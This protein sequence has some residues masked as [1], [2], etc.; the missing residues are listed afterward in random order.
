M[1]L[2][3]C[4]INKAIWTYWIRGCKMIR[5]VVPFVPMNIDDPS[6][7]DKFAFDISFISSTIFWY[8]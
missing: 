7:V 2:F 1:C 3:A 5:T 6:H 4:A 8:V